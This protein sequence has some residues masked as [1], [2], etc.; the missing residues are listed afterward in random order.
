MPE[1]HNCSN[2]EAE[3]ERKF[4]VKTLQTKVCHQKKKSN[5]IRNSVINNT[6]GSRFTTELRS[7]ILGCKSNRKTSNI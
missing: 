3:V 1:T 2:G 4:G 5:E 6:A 7:R